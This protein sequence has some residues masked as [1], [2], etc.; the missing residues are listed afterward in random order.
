MVVG[1]TDSGRTPNPDLYSRVTRRDTLEAE[2]HA[3]REGHVVRHLAVHVERGGFLE[4]E[5]AQVVLRHEPNAEVRIELDI[6]PAAEVVG[7][8]RC[9]RVHEAGPDLVADTTDATLNERGDQRRL[10]HRNLELDAAVIQERLARADT[11]PT[12]DR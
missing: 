4:V 3:K 7:D 11:E 8:V 5:L 9:R 12:E 6:E 10:L 2:V 1:R